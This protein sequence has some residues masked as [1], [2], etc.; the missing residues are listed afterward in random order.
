M[1]Q[2]DSLWSALGLEV[3]LFFKPIEDASAQGEAALVEFLSR[4]GIESLSPSLLSALQTL[5]SEVGPNPYAD[6][7]S[8]PE[9]ADFEA[10]LQTL[11]AAA[12]TLF[13]GAGD[14]AETLLAYLLDQYLLLNH[15]KV[16]SLLCLFGVLQSQE[17]VPPSLD[18]TR[19]A[20][21]RDPRRLIRDVYGWGTADFDAPNLFR[22]IRN[23]LRAFGADASLEKPTQTALDAVDAGAVLKRNTLALPLLQRVFEDGT[24][25]AVGLVAIPLEGGAASDKGVA[26]FPELTASFDSGALGP[27]WTVSFDSRAAAGYAAILRPSGPAIGQLPGAAGDP[28]ASF[29]ARLSRAS[30]TPWLLKLGDG[31]SLS[32]DSIQ[33]SLAYQLSNSPAFESSLDVRGFQVVLAPPAGD[34]FLSAILPPDGLTARSDFTIEWSNTD[35]LQ[36][37]GSAGFST[38]LELNLDIGPLTITDLELSVQLGGDRGALMLGAGVGL[39]AILGPVRA[40]VEGLGLDFA[41]DLAAPGTAPSSGQGTR[42]GPFATHVSPRLPTAIGLVVDSPPVTGGGF[43]GRDPNTA[44]YYGGLQL[45]FKDIGLTAVGIL[46]TR[47]P[48]G[49]RGYSL[50][51]IIGVEFSPAIPLGYGFFLSGVGGLLGTNRRMDLDALEER[52]WTGAVDSILFPEDPVGNMGSLIADLQAIFPVAPHRFVFGPMATITWGSPAILRAE[53]GIFIELP[54]PVRI[55]LL[56]KLTVRLP[57]QDKPLVNLEMDVAGILDPSAGELKI[58]GTLRDSTV[59][60]LPV[61]GDM[62]LLARWGANPAFAASV[63]GFHPKFTP[64]EGM[65]TLHRVGIS[66]GSGDNPRIELEGYLALTSNTAQFGA[67]VEIEASR[68]GFQ[69][70]GYLGFDALFQFSPFHVLIGMSGGV[71]ISK[72]GHMITSATLEASLEGPKPWHAWGKVEFEAL[73]CKTSIHF[74]AEFGNR[75]AQ[76]ELPVDDPTPLLEAALEEP[77]NWQATFPTDQESRVSFRAEPPG[78]PTGAQ[79]ASPDGSFG[80]RQRVLPLGVTITRFGNA[81]TPAPLTLDIALR[82][83]AGTNLDQTSLDDSF[84]PAQFF[85]FSDSERLSSPGFES[86]KAGFEISAGDPQ[87]GPSASVPVGFEQ[88]EIGAPA[89]P[90][91]RKAALAKPSAAAATRSAGVLLAEITGAL[92]ASARIAAASRS[93]DDRTIVVGEPKYTIVSVND[94]R[95]AA[96]LTA[97]RSF[98]RA[99]AQITLRNYSGQHPDEGALLM[100]ARESEAR[101]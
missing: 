54:S 58:L 65:P 7:A 37:K 23:L 50:L 77:R 59:V 68:A 62:A 92:P 80:F 69:A 14:A 90:A 18:W 53:I 74:D 97:G 35:G 33:L 85:E 95:R 11:R 81:R 52:F 49:S 63:G 89:T 84:A 78:F 55:A 57:Q 4:V 29:A 61:H 19:L 76:G 16:H 66:L 94:L 75:E 36:F 56:G 13:A 100:V 21:L 6:P 98:D 64:P 39:R 15:W 5:A 99:Q 28:S 48:D 9:R 27:N 26:V 43:L 38:T 42:V 82:T 101:A 8:L 88:F 83:P 1:T 44:S 71:S 51:G 40:A 93:A 2:D 34:G 12:E 20:L 91:V 24:I 67:R 25:V 10:R 86:H 46:T 60:G 41:F 30:G 31:L 22:C 47:M 32:A 87:L 70:H 72:F 73:G 45:A 79:L 3:R 96:V 17:G